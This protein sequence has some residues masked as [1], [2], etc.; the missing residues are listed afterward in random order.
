[1]A[2]LTPNLARELRL[3]CGISL[4]EMADAAGVSQQLISKVELGDGELTPSHEWMLINAFEVVAASRKAC[5]DELRRELK[6]YKAKRLKEDFR[7][8]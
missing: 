8:L 1:M 2:K 6:K 4:Q 3:R 5:M 7:G